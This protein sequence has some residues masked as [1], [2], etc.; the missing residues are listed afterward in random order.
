MI[1][2]ANY[3]STSDTSYRAI[4]QLPSVMHYSKPHGSRLDMSKLKDLSDPKHIRSTSEASCYV[5][6]TGER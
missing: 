5:Y 4:L 3:S 2:F 6:I 1:S